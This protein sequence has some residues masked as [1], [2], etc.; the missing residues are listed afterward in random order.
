MSTG[1]QGRCNRSMRWPSSDSSWALS[2]IQPATPRVAPASAPTAP[3]TRPLA[4]R[5]S[6]MCR[7]LAPIAPSMPS[8]RSRRWAITVKPATAS[9]PTNTSP[10]VASTSTTTVDVSASSER[11]WIDMSSGHGFV[12]KS[13]LDAPMS[14]STWSSAVTWPGATRT[15]ASCRF[16]GFSTRPTTARRLPPWSQVPP[17]CS[18]KIFA[19][20]SVTAISS[21]PC[22]H[23]PRLSRSIVRPYAPLGSWARTST[24]F[25]DPG[26]GILFS[27]SITSTVPNELRSLARSASS[28]APVLTRVT[29][30]SAVPNTDACDGAL[31]P[32]P[33]P[34]VVAA[35]A[36][37]SRA[38]TINCWRHSR[39]NSR[40][41][42]RAT[43]RR[44]GIP[45]WRLPS[46]N[47]GCSTATLIAL[48]PRP[49]RSPGQGEGRCG[50]PRG[51]RE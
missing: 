22:G 15:N 19:T 36:T 46:T 28:W 4:S 6:R 1:V 40:Q 27:C 18:R 10:I 30:W 44:A 8:A 32:M 24:P 39:R 21:G 13:A 5:A 47:G 11:I 16:S 20:R 45:P 51:R 9:R 14:T 7:W 38:S 41:A 33:R 50:R 37:S 31:A 2:A 26:T 23:R 12:V 48:P 42:Q 35:T 49:A 29:R 17:T 34:T 25:A 3:M 43:A